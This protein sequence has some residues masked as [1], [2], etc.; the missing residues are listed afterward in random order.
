[1][2]PNANTVEKK[3]KRGIKV[4]VLM[5]SSIIQVKKHDK[6]ELT[7]IAREFQ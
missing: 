3:K 2:C 1:M 6:S 5:N 7:A 4:L